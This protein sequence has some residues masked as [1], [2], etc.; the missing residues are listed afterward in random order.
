ISASTQLNVG[1]DLHGF[2]WVTDMLDFT[3][4]VTSLHLIT[5]PAGNI[6][7][8]NNPGPDVIVDQFTPSGELEPGGENGFEVFELQGDLTAVS[9]TTLVIDISGPDPGNQIGDHDQVDVAGTI[10]LS[11]SPVLEVL[12]RNA[13]V[14]TLDQEFVIINND[15][16]DAV[17]GTF[18][19]LAEGATIN[20]G[21]VEFEIS[22]VGGDGNDVVLTAVSVNVEEILIDGFETLL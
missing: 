19:G 6:E 4:L 1:D 10:D 2:I 11:T 20:V 7:V 12:L 22:Y 15:G 3:G 9:S 16:V 21:N 13:Y 8:A 5:D 14:P 17:T 18:S